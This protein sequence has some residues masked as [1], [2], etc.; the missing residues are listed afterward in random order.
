MNQHNA[1]KFRSQT[2]ATMLLLEKNG[3]L[4]EVKENP[5]LTPGFGEKKPQM[6]TFEVKLGTVVLL[7]GKR[8]WRV[9]HGILGLG[10]ES[11]EETCLSWQT[12]T[13]SPTS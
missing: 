13:P 5:V 6:N 1:A 12:N 10:T 2:L 8:C 4:K 7:Y 3:D 11:E 9:S